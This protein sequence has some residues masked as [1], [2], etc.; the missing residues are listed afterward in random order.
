MQG[1]Q[2]GATTPLPSQISAPRSS[3]GHCKLLLILAFGVLTHKCKGPSCMGFHP[4]HPTQ[5]RWIH[6]D[7]LSCHQVIH[8]WPLQKIWDIVLFALFYVILSEILKMD[9]QNGGGII[10]LHGA[11]VKSKFD[12]LKSQKL[13]FSF[14]PDFW[15]P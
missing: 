10:L 7:I 2:V 8:F 4:L 15:N 11:F 3:L 6:F 5:P 9:V 12:R 13:R 1:R 14:Y